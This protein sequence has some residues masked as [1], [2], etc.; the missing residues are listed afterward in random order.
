MKNRKRP[1]AKVGDKESAVGESG[2]TE[3]SLSIA[4]TN[5]LRASL[6]L[7]PLQE[8]PE[9]DTAQRTFGLCYFLFYFAKY[10]FKEE[11]KKKKE[12]EAIRE[13]LRI[14]KEK[15]KEEAF[16]SKAKPLGKRSFNCYRFKRLQAK[17][18]ADLMMT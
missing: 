10:G 12:T 6:G 13:R 5:K 9:D 18:K 2:T 11:E 8:K 1:S 3:V 4:E 16:F 17:P 14:A 7:K 15:R